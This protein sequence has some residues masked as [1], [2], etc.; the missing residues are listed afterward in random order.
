MKHMIRCRDTQDPFT[1]VFL[2]TLIMAHYGI[3][4]SMNASVELDWSHFFR[5]K[6]FKETKC[7]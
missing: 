2:I 7:G 1:Y 4:L 5:K 6:N 3:N